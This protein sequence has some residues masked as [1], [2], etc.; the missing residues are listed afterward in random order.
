MGSIAGGRWNC[1]VEATL[2]AIGGKW[3]PLI[4]WH[5]QQAPER[6]SGLR[7]L[8]PQVTE[9]ML[10]QQLRELERDELVVRTVYA[11]SP[12]GRVCDE[13]ARQDAGTRPQ[14]HVRLGRRADPQGEP[15]H[16]IH[17]PG[18]WPPRASRP[19]TGQGSR[20]SIDSP[21]GSA[22]AQQMDGR[23]R[24]SRVRHDGLELEG[25][26]DLQR[27]VAMA[28]VLAEQ[29]GDTLDPLVEVLAWTY[30][31]AAVRARLASDWK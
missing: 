28:P 17:A 5:L 8:I 4:L 6:F 18:H 21:A 23:F 27:V 16:R 20:S 31:L 7:R 19:L 3:K 13:R 26:V 2:E 25:Q 30:S 12:E 11:G 24:P 1:G 15:R 14:G 22:T 10:T 29:R 9:K